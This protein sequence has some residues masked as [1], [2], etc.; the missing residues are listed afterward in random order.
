MINGADVLDGTIAA[1]SKRAPAIIAAAARELGQ[2]RLH[3]MFGDGSSSLMQARQSALK[4]V[5][6][7]Q[8]TDTASDVAVHFDDRA[9]ML[10]FDA[11]QRPSDQAL[12]QSLDMRGSR[13]DLLAVWRCFRLLSQRAAGL[14]VVQA[15]WSD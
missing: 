3:L 8:A 5:H 1:L 4:V 7:E 14:R 10:L 13:E 12:E 2:I 6:A 11:I 9:L 15:L